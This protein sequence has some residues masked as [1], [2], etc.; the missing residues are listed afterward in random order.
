MLHLFFKRKPLDKKQVKNLA[1]GVHVITQVQ[2]DG[3]KVLHHPQHL[4]IRNL[5]TL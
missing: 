5:Q 3:L 1:A 4:F 2:L